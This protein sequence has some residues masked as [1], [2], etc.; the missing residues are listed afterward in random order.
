MEI[1]QNSNIARGP[2]EGIAVKET[3][4][5]DQSSNMARGPHERIAAKER[6]E[7]DQ[8]SNMARGPLPE[9]RGKGNS[10]DRSELKHGPGSPTRESW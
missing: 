6:V 10:R 2:N 1:D 5:T 3:V 8:S 7:T 9:N 4:E